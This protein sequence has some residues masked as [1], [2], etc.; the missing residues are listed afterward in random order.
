MEFRV[1]NRLGQLVFETK[2]WTKKW[3][4]KIKGI[5]QTTG[6]YAWILSFTNHDTG[7]KVFMKGTTLLIR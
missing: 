1:Y 2:D 5:V 7:E 4:G 3:D 6:V